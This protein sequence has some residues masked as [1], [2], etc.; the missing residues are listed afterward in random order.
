MSTLITRTPWSDELGVT[1]TEP[2]IQ[3]DVTESISAQAIAELVAMDSYLDNTKVVI[4]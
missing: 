3:N 1:A 2:N 4:R